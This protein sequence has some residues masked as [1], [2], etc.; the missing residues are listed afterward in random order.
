MY[1]CQQN[2]ISNQEILPFLDYLCTEAN[3]LTNCGIYLARQL[4]FKAN[5]I[6]GKYDLEKNLKQNLHFQFLYSQA[7]QQILRSVAESFASFKALNK[8]FYKGKLDKKPK[9]PNYRKS[10]G[11]ALITYPKQALK[12]V[13]NQIRIPLGKK[14]KVI[15]R[16]AQD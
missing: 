13:D 1:A 14:V 12:L 5:Y 8:L 3:S 11:L 6:V 7:A 15:L 4:D 2:L 10:G 16:G 9:L